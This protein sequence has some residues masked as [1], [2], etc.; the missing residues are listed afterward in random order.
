MSRARPGTGV[1]VS[2]GRLRVDAARAIDKLRSYQLAD[3][4]AWV[5]EVVRAGVVFPGSAGVTVEGSGGDVFVALA[6]TPPP[7]ARLPKLFEDLVD[8]GTDV[9]SRARRLLAIGV[10]AALGRAESG[11]ATRHV[12]VYVVDDEGCARARFTPQLLAVEKETGIAEGLRALATEAVALPPH[13]PRPERG[14]VVHARA[15]MGISLLARWAM[16]EEPRELA[17]VRE[18]CREVRVPVVVQGLPIPADPSILMRE[19]LPSG[20]YVALVAPRVGREGAVLEAAEAGVVLSRTPWDAGVGRSGTCVPLLLRVDR[21]RLPTNAARSAVRWDEPGIAPVLDEAREALAALVARLAKEVDETTDPARLSWLRTVAITLIAS[22]LRGASFLNQI[23]DRAMVSVLWPLLDAKLLFDALGRRRTPRELASGTETR[24]HLDRTFLPPELEP[25]LG[26]VLAA[27]PGDPTHLLFGTTAPPASAAF[28]VEE[29]LSAR[30]REQAWLARPV[31]PPVVGDAPDALARV[32]L[33]SRVSIKGRPTFALAGEVVLG[34]PGDS[35]RVSLRRGGRV[36]ETR[37][38]PAGV[39]VIGVAD[40]DAFVPTLAYDGVVVDDVSRAVLDAIAD[41]VST[42]CEALARVLVGERSVGEASVASLAATDPRTPAL[43]RWG[44]LAL[45]SADADEARALTKKSVLGRAPVWPSLGADL[46]LVALAAADA[47]GIVPPGR[48]RPAYVPAHRPVLVVAD[49]ERTALKL[50]MPRAAFVDYTRVRTPRSTAAELTLQAYGR[51]A[52]VGLALEAETHALVIS[53]GSGDGGLVAS[54]AGVRMG[55]H[56]LRSPRVPVLALVDDDH[57]VPDE[58]WA[59]SSVDWMALEERHGLGLASGRIARAVVSAW[60]GTKSPALFHDVPL[61]ATEVVTAVL[62]EARVPFE[63]P[64]SPAER[65][66]L[67]ALPILPRIDGARTSID[68]IAAAN[69]GRIAYVTPESLAAERDAAGLALEIF[70]GSREAALGIVALGGV[71][72]VYDATKD[73]AQAIVARRRA[74]RLAAIASRPEESIELAGQRETVRVQGEGVDGLVGFRAYAAASSVTL[75][76]D[77]R[78][79]GELEDAELPPHLVARVSIEPRLV[80]PTGDDLDETGR[81]RVRGALLAAARQLLVAVVRSRPQALFADAPLRALASELVGNGKRRRGE[82]GA[83]LRSLSELETLADTTGRPLSIVGAIVDDELLFVDEPLVL[84]E[85]AEDE[86]PSPLDRPLAYV[87][88]EPS[89]PRTILLTKLADAVLKNVVRD[90]RA[91]NAARKR[92]R[93]LVARPTLTR[94]AEPSLSRPLETLLRGT[95]DE[96][97]V[98]KALAAGAIGLV[99]SGPSRAR[100]FVDGAVVHETKLDL[101]PAFEAAVE[102]PLVSGARLSAAA[103]AEIEAALVRTLAQ[104]LRRLTDERA[105]DGAPDWAVDAQRDAALLGGKTHL[106]RLGSLRL[107]PTTAGTRVSYDEIRAQHGR[108]GPVWVTS[109]DTHVLPLDPERFC[110]RLARAHATAL[111]R[112]VPVMEGTKELELDQQ[113]RQNRSRPPV[114]SLDPTEDERAAVLRV[115]R[116][117][118]PDGTELVVMPLWP[119]H[120]SEHHVTYCLGVQPLGSLDGAGTIPSIVRVRSPELV[121][122]RTW[123][124]PVRDETVLAL[125]RRADALAEQAV[126]AAITAPPSSFPSVAVDPALLVPV[127]MPRHRVVRGALTLGPLDEDD[128]EN[129]R[130]VD[131]S[132]DDPA[133]APLVALRATAPK[134]MPEP[135]PLAG[136][137]VL[138]GDDPRR[139]ETTLDAVARRAYGAL[140]DALATRLREGRSPD[141]DLDRAHLVYGASLGFLPGKGYWALAMPFG[142]GDLATFRG[143]AETFEKAGLVVALDPAELTLVD[144]SGALARH[145]AFVRDGSLASARLALALGPRVVSRSDALALAL[146]LTKVPAPRPETRSSERPKPRTEPAAPKGKSAKKAA[147]VRVSAGPVEPLAARARHAL[148]QAGHE[149]VQVEV[150]AARTSPIVRMLDETMSLA[151]SS[152]LLALAA[153]T[154]VHRERAATILAAHAVLS[155]RGSVTEAY[156]AFVGLLA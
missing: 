15:L 104:L 5:L 126:I 3:P 156:R 80:G 78:A 87:P 147:S 136:T 127:S 121:P 120:A 101:V 53:W 82:V 76:V 40:T 86:K 132:V 63:Q 150:E 13:A 98:L 8:A 144:E 89:D 92:A 130:L 34:A 148:V 26:N 57:L 9:E 23:A 95:D 60:L 70:V 32:H 71:K 36:L 41:A 50:L 51:D 149:N 151:G 7:R 18:A 125:E 119:A 142:R 16:G 91:L 99:P 128:R 19:P 97:V 107:F 116:E 56:A 85:R 140:L 111:G 129:V 137:L 93:G 134:R 69:D 112:A 75:L 49:A 88:W 106:E 35:Y 139:A 10:N 22:E 48:P 100:F 29:A 154:G 12:D 21:E 115:E 45:V 28:F 61:D 54:H 146:G 55:M 11:T 68:A 20:G 103:R 135:V 152:E 133:D 64:L 42:G 110:L 145:P 105:F 27:P 114:T 2:G 96:K 66:A 14:V 118:D 47:I 81:A 109:V 30:Q 44:I 65:R 24:V 33:P 94:A 102:S 37:M 62:L 1:R 58:A 4:L 38:R 113:A 122:D 153:G 31:V 155:A 72:D 141:E 67:R 83:M 17:L 59:S 108:F 43:V 143:I 52:H 84:V 123:S 79:F 6:C 90:V 117:T 74:V 124:A 77:R 138:W 46:S 131:A 39:G 25:W 73:V